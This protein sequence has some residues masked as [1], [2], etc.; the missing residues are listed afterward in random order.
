MIPSWVF[1]LPLSL[2]S[3]EAKKQ[4]IDVNLISAIVMVESAGREC[5]VR[6]EHNYRWLFHHRNFADDQGI[7]EQTEETFQK[8]SWGLMQVMGA[9]ARELGYKGPLVELCNPKLGLHYGCLKLK[10]LIEREDSIEDAIASYN[11]GQ[12]V[13]TRGGFYLPG[14]TQKYVDKVMKK[15]K[16]LAE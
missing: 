1:L 4:N 2:I 6:Y 15:Y 12:A 7:T 3:Q 8:T 5:A 13:K 16:E 10:E 11:A 14:T 9:V